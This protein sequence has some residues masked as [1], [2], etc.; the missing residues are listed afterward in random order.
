VR[1]QDYDLHV[2][3]ARYGALF[4]DFVQYQATVHENIGYGDIARQADRHAIEAAAQRA[5]ASGLIGELPHSYDTL[6]GQMFD[7]AR[8]LSKGQWQL[9]ALAR[10][11]FHEAPIV[12]LDEPTAALSPSKE[13]EVFA[14]LRA[15]LRAD[16]IDI[17]VSHRFST[18]RLADD[19]I[20]IE[21]AT[22]REQDSHEELIKLGGT[23]ARLYTIQA[24]AY[25]DKTP[26]RPDVADG[27]ENLA[28]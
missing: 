8:E 28:T 3:R 27:A 1:L 15:S 26:D 12:I 9:M 19:I 16:Q 7:G 4:Q 18:V 23:Y 13:Q 6:L 25:A 2:L 21:G 20:V 17:I 22:I 24:R 14:A 5:G 11:L 10:A